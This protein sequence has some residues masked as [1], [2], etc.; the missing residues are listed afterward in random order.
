M[1]DLILSEVET[2][3]IT[4]RNQKVILDCDVAQLYGVQTK[5]IN[6]AVRNNPEKFPE[7][8]V[9]EL[10]ADENHSLRSKFLTLKKSWTFFS[11]PFFTAR[12]EWR[13]I[14]AVVSNKKV[15]NLTYIGI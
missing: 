5:E 7:G 10:D 1:N 15:L 2:R 13:N 9:F 3:I 8:Y 4:L 12:K 6:Q 11:F 14:G